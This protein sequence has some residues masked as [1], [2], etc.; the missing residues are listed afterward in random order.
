MKKMKRLKTSWSV[1]TTIED[2][3]DPGLNENVFISD[4]DVDADAHHN[5][6]YIS[7]HIFNREQMTEDTT[8][9]YLNILKKIRLSIKIKDYAVT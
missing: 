3:I 9:Y 6:F 5:A 1:D 7:K 4:Q 2:N 8:M